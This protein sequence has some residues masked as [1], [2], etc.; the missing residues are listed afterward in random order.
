LR[1]QHA[2]GPHNQ[3]VDFVFD[4][5]MKEGEF[6]QSAWTFA[7]GEVPKE[8]KPFLGGTPI[9]RDEKTFLPLQAADRCLRHAH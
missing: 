7:A 2:N 5:Q 6:A 8:V 9:H 1:Y 3:Q 4:E